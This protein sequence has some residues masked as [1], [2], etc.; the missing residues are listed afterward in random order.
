MRRLRLHLGRDRV[1][2]RSLLGAAAALTLAIVFAVLGGEVLE[3]DT[4]AFDMTC[5]TLQDHCAPPT[6]GYPASCAT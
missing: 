2:L 4:Q 1:L 6:H 5:S 3:G